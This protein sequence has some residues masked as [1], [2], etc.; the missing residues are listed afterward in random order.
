MTSARRLLLAIPASF[1]LLVAWL[2]WSALGAAPRLA[3]ENLRGAGL[4]SAAAIEQLAQADPSFGLLS[5]YT[6]ADIAYF[7]LLDSDGTV[8]FHT[9]PR[10]VGTRA[11]A[12]DTAPW[13]GGIGETRMRLGTG[14]EVYLLRT[15]VHADG[16]E[17]LLV[18]AL[19]T[20]RADRVIRMVDAALSVV[21]ALTV[22]LWCLTGFIFFL[23]RREERHKRALQQRQELARIGEMGAVLAHEIRNPLAAIK[24]FAQLVQDA[25][26]A[27]QAHRHAEKIVRQSLRMETLVNN[28]LAFAHDAVTEREEADLAVVVRE[29][30]AL[31]QQEAEA[32]KVRIDLEVPAP[33]PARV[34][35]DRVHQMLLNLMK[36]ALQAMPEGGTL[37]VA[38]HR[39]AHGIVISVKDN[40]HGISPDGLRH[41]FEP[42]W[43]TRARGTGLGLAICRKVAQ[44]HDGTLTVSSTVGSGTECIVTLPAGN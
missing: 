11:P 30:A 16:S 34:V 8:R 18:L 13:R 15:R 41:V 19:H 43:T 4:S 9:N 29:C 44:E 3:T 12:G 5:R 37:T 25:P 28:L 6:S 32:Q 31:L 17:Y 27:E 10:L 21:S 23:L 35:V 22:A 24:G 42:F 1:T 26:T 36:N 7:A 33:L 38:G 40:G 39:A 14:E 20:Y 2:A